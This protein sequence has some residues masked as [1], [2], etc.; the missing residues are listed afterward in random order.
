M[1]QNLEPSSRATE[2]TVDVYLLP[3]GVSL[4]VSFMHTYSITLYLA[5]SLLSLQIST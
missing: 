5:I 1:E 2:P 3:R 4:T